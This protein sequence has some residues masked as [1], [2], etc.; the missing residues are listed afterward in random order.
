[1]NMLKLLKSPLY[2]V[3][4]FIDD[5]DLCRMQQT[6]KYLKKHASE[7]FLWRFL[8]QSKQLTFVKG[9]KQNWLA[10]YKSKFGAS[11]NL[12][13]ESFS[14]ECCTLRKHFSDLITG[15]EVWNNFVAAYSK[16]ELV[17]FLLDEDDMSESDSVKVN[18]IKADVLSCRF[19]EMTWDS[20]FLVVL[21]NDSSVHKY[22]ITQTHKDQFTLELVISKPGLLSHKF[23]ASWGRQQLVLCYNPLVQANF[24]QGNLTSEIHVVSLVDLT[25][26]SVTM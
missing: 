4:K 18:K 9:F 17:L 10:V 16:Q 15:T 24:Y 8:L 23:E 5:R 14:Y 6:C 7:D 20:A 13:K 2:E 19:I 1:M 11:R 25:V 26:R 22:K 3:L 21:C 12:K